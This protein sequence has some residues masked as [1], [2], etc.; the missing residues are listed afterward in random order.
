MRIALL[1][2]EPGQAHLITSW[3]EAAGH[4]CQSFERGRLMV[5]QL[6]RESFDLLILDRMVPDMSGEEVMGWVREHIPIPPRVL[7]VTSRDS[8]DE[9]AMILRSGGDDYMV[10]PARRLEL[11]A[12]V[13]ALGRRGTLS[14]ATDIIDAAPYRIDPARRTVTLSGAEVTLTNTEFELARFLFRNV[15]RL[16]S[17][18]HL[19]ESVWGRSGSIDTRTVDTYLSRLRKKLHI[20]PEHGWRL[21]AIYQQGYRLERVNEGGEAPVEEQT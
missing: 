6:G 5:R 20:G 19:L 9:I 7:F 12:R 1:E 18:G 3:L 13:E 4:S 8:E 16:L 10:K 2:D 14:T 17:R 21:N 15:G 11:L